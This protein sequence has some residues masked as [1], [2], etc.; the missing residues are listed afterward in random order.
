MNDSEV[1]RLMPAAEQKK[2]GR[3][4]KTRFERPSQYAASRESCR[5]RRRRRLLKIRSGA[6]AGAEGK[7]GKV[8]PI[9]ALSSGIKVPRIDSTEHRAQ[10]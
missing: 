6:G 3:S 7:T 1:V 10:C 5:R 8:V 2:L 9:L 4:G